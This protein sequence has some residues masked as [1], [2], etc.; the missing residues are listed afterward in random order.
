M[1]KLLMVAAAVT[2]AVATASGFVSQSQAASAKS[3]YC[4]LAKN[5]R[6]VPSWNEHYGCLRAPAREA[7]ARAPEPTRAVAPAR[8]KGPKS[9]FCAL[10]LAQRNAPSWNDYYRCR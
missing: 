6:N 3:Q 4:D 7:F 9:E 5:Q 2:I 8:A 10:A 1:R